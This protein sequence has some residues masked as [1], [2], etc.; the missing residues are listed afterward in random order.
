[1]DAE[2]VIEKILSDAKNQADRFDKE[3]DEKASGEQ[4]KLDRQLQEYKKQTEI[5]AQKAADDEK[6][7]LLA[8][9]RMDISKDYLAEKRKILDD[10]FER[11][12]AQLQN[13][14]D[15][16]Y[17]RLMTKLMLEAVETGDEEVIVDSSETRIDQNFIEHINHELGPG[18]KGNLRLSRQRQK[19]G[20]GFVLRRGR[21]KNNVSIEVLLALARKDLEIE[22]A[23]ELF[24][25]FQ[26]R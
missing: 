2:Q 7:H 25:D 24:A 12:R 26:D 14:P 17:R 21:V 20:G 11:A 22:L 15:E 1:M 23:K 18:R 6:S 4:A 3:A 9:A 13:L 16:D 10:V 8:A 19:M 5:L